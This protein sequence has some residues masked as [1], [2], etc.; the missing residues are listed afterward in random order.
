MTVN[1]IAARFAGRPL[2]I[3][4][5][6]LEPLLAAKSVLDKTSA[7]SVKTDAPANA[8][9]RYALA[10]HG[11]AVV[12]IVGPLLSRGDWLTEMFGIMSYADVG[13]AVDTAFADPAVNAVLLEVDSPGGEVG[14]LFDLVEQ[15]R[16]ARASTG[17]PVWA[18]ASESALS[19]GYAIA[20][21]ADRLYVTR[22]GEVGSIGVVAAHVDESAA[23]AMAG[24]KWTLIQ[25]GAKKTDG[26]SHEPLAPDA[27]A[28][29]QADVDV[30]Y[31]D[32]VALVATNRSITPE[33]IRS[34]EAAI[35]RGKRALA[36][37]L[38]DQIGT[39]DRALADL[40]VELTKTRTAASRSHH[41][42]SSEQRSSIMT[43]TERPAAT[44]ETDPSP[45]PAAGPV[46]TAGPVP[47]PPSLLAPAAPSAPVAAHSEAEA[48]RAEYSEIAGIA[49]QA[50]RLGVVIDAADAMKKAV[51]PDGLRRSVLDA[52]AARSEASAVVA[53][54]PQQPTAGVSP[55]VRRARE[56]AAAGKN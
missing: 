1:M 40:G 5:R 27:F 49:A 52:L 45:A 22:T 34:T 43:K 12:P 16:E 24:Q 56:R 32:F 4:P 31:A 46:P 25:A 44:P 55:I 50:A 39:I 10:D 35:Y 14:G 13:D 37:G 30:L 17:K 8:P 9:R 26:N 2:A 7:T 33:A 3:A 54:V 53:A 20:S 41:A 23:D 38:A 42:F 19:A 47:A 11:I 29:I 51:K 48:L 28:E 21:T 36:V 15:I 6:A 18:V